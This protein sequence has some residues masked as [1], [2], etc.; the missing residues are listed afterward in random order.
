MGTSS[1]IR[2]TTEQDNTNLKS[3]YC[4]FS[5]RAQGHSTNSPRNFSECLASTYN[6]APS[7]FVEVVILLLLFYFREQG[8]QRS[9]APSASVRT[10]T[11]AEDGED[12]EACLACLKVGVTFNPLILCNLSFL[13]VSLS[14]NLQA[15]NVSPV[16]V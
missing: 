7:T 15:S 14:A 9:T 4:T 12:G 6:L 1:S 2:E 13:G 5:Q 16:E 11:S 3:S 10:D 8:L